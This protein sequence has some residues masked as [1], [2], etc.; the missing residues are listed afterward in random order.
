MRIAPKI[1]LFLWLVSIFC[2]STSAAS[3]LDIF[4]KYLP[5][6]AVADIYQETKFLYLRVCNL[7]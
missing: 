4:S 2:N 6:I 7:G 5:D 1:F 3:P